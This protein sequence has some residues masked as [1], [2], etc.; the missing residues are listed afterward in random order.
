MID[1]ENKLVRF[2][3]PKEVLIGVF[4]FLSSLVFF[5]LLYLRSSEKQ[6]KT[7]KNEDI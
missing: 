2:Y 3:I 5:S 6:R 4:R 7:L 1:L